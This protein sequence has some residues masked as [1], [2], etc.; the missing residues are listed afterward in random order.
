MRGP[1]RLRL[2]GGQVVAPRVWVAT[3]LWDSFRGLM[4][5][6]RLDSQE[7][8]TLK[9][10]QIHMFFMRFA[11]DAAFINRQGRI[12]RVLAPIRPWRIS[13]Y[14]LGAHQVVELAPG[15]LSRAGARVG[16]TLVLEQD[17]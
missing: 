3:N 6:P 10:K 16:D 1:Y 13:P 7:G 15:T 12:V 11:I 17:G 4:M 14:V 5:R 2:A 9:G 8:L